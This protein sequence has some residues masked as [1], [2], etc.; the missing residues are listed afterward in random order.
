MLCLVVR[1]DGVQSS[2]VVSC[3]VVWRIAVPCS[4]VQSRFVVPRSA[5]FRRGME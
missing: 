4:D 2:S 1:S 3:V 5:V